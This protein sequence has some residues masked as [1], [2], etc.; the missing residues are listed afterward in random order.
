MLIMHVFLLILGLVIVLK[1]GDLFV[2]S[3]VAIA[4]DLKI[5]RVVVGGTIVSLATTA[6]EL[7]V[8]VTASFMKNPGIALGNAVGSAIANIALI[9]GILAVLSHI[10]V[11]IVD[12]RRRSVWMLM[13][14]V[15]VI[16]FSWNLILP[17]WAALALLVMAAAYL[18]LDYHIVTQDKKK[19]VSK[20]AEESEETMPLKKAIMIFILGAVLVVIGSRLLVNSG[21]VIAEALGIPSVIIGLTIIAVGTSLPELITAVTAAKKGVPDLSI[22]NIVGANT[23]DLTFI[24]GASGTIHPLTLSA[25][26]RNYSYVW[27]MVIIL[28]MMFMFWRK[29]TAGKKEGVILLTMY[30]IYIAGLILLPA[31]ATAT[32]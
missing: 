31:L 6:P 32:S 20:P 27:M 14:A 2:D 5:P 22:G 9:I 29:G 17:F 19:N 26:T 12:F 15:L 28:T 25:F 13:A 30:V 21:I 24:I 16:L 10:K 23:L 8:S 3:S 1:G 4:R 7:I 11:D 18:Y